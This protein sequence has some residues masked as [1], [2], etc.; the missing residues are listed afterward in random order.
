MDATAEQELLACL[1][2]HAGLRTAGAPTP[3]GPGTW[4]LSIDGRA[5][6]VKRML[7]AHPPAVF[8]QTM[9]AIEDASIGCPPLLDCLEYREHWYALFAFVDGLPLRRPRP[10]H[11]GWDDVF[12][13]LA[14]LATIARPLPP[15]NIERAWLERVSSLR[16]H[17]AIAARL[18]DDLAAHPPIGVP[19]LAHGDFAPQ[20]FLETSSGLVL[21]DWEEAGA[22]SPGF[23][24]GWLLALNRIG[25]GLRMNRDA[26]LAR[27]TDL[28]IPLSNALWFEGLGLL[29]L[30]WRAT[31]WLTARPEFFAVVDKI[32]SAVGR[33]TDECVGAPSA[34]C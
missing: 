22:A 23:D 2:N 10:G 34:G 25:A 26:L 3:L 11:T 7:P 32:Q 4:R 6:V 13:L 15:G 16:G 27:V 30:Q 1:A 9:A 14:R 18:L 8:R 5:V 21:I 17:D 20:N 19:C 33:F 29:R 12:A 24:A 28:R 31:S